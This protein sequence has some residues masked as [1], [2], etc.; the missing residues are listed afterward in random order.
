MYFHDYNDKVVN[1]KY[2]YIF[3]YCLSIYTYIYIYRERER[4]RTI[5]S[6]DTEC[7]SLVLLAFLSAFEIHHGIEIAPVKI[8]KDHLI[9]S[10][11]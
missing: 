2:I 6:Y 10:D 9:A 3:V 7:I 5:S 4:E 8:A 11:E 1:C